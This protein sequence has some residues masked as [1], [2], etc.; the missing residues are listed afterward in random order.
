MNIKKL[1]K[2]ALSTT[3]AVTSAAGSVVWGASCSS[4]SF[5]PTAEI[6]NKD[7]ASAVVTFVIDDGNIPTADF[8]KE[9][10]ESYDHLTFTYAIWTKDFAT[11]ETTADGSEYVMVNGKYVYTQTAAQQEKQDRK[12][13]V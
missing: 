11:L 6:V 7:G 5:K 8:A 12:S 13:V 3:L 2:K 9:M 4:A 1:I 10:M